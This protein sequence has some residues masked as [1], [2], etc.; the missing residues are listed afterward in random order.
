MK[1]Q[2]Y[3]LIKIEGFMLFRSQR[4]KSL[5]IMIFGFSICSYIASILTKG[6]DSSIGLV[7]LS[8]GSINILYSPFQFSWDRKFFYK[9]ITKT[10]YLKSYIISK[11]LIQQ[12]GIIII[13]ISILPLLLVYYNDALFL[14]ISYGLYCFCFA[15]ILGIILSSRNTDIIN[16]KTTRQVSYRLHNILQVF[17]PIIP[18]IIF[19]VISNKNHSYLIDFNLIMSIT[20]ILLIFPSIEL[21]QK[22]LKKRKY[23]IT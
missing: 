13:T 5:V 12:I 21:S 16:L 4:T 3:Q 17:I 7:F 9:Q 15:S 18:L 23:I 2:I 10:Q 20:G 11:I 19:V 1:S 14:M 6:G 22:N 8:I